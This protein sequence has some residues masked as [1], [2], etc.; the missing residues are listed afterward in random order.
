MLREMHRKLQESR[1]DTEDGKTD[2]LWGSIVLA[3]FFF[4]RSSELRGPVARD[5]STG[6]TTHCIK[7]VD[8][9]LRN[10][11]GVII[12]PGSVAAH[13]AEILYRS[14]KGDQPLVPSNRSGDVFTRTSALAAWR[15]TPRPIPNLGER[16]LD[17]QEIRSG[18]TNQTSGTNPRIG[19]KQL[20]VSFDANR[21]C[22]CTTRGREKGNSHS[23]Y[24]KM[25][26][27]V[28]LGVHQTPTRHA[29]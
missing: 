8:V 7:A 26:K 10:R 23:T 9:I 2:L 3:F 11:H 19:S 15:Q 28:L 27:L 4:D 20:C 5:S 21:W 14:H 16:Y 24:G 6:G 29:S 12:E 18:H 25:G 1:N 17:D 13:S 22:L